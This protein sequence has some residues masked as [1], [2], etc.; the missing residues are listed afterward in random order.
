[1]GDRSAL[2]SLL[3]LLSNRTR[4]SILVAL[5]KPRT[6]STIAST[7]DITTKK[8]RYH[9]QRLMDAGLVE[10]VDDDRPYQYQLTRRVR[11]VRYQGQ[12]VC[13]IEAEN[14]ERLVVSESTTK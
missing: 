7:L 13:E 10:L 11:I 8:T 14:G 3:R 12:T 1:M 9:L 4:R 2:R 5:K 6:A